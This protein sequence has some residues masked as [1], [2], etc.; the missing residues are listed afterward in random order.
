[1]YVFLEDKAGYGASFTAL[2]YCFETGSLTTPEICHL[3]RLARSRDLCSNA[4]VK[5]MCVSDDLF[6]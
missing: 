4:E 2:S 1:M 6:M 5:G 3:T